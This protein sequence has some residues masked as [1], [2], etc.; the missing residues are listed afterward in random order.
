MSTLNRHFIDHIRSRVAVVADS[1]KRGDNEHAH[2]EE[3][4]GSGEAP[5]SEIAREALQSR[6]V[7]YGAVVFV[8]AETQWGHLPDGWTPSEGPIVPERA[9]YICRTCGYIDNHARSYCKN[10]NCPGTVGIEKVV[11]THIRGLASERWR[12]SDDLGWPFE[13]SP[14]HVTRR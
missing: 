14:L 3:D 2:A 1:V 7:V 9:I 4:D 13:E 10:A 6:E 11:L 5:P 12:W 8:T